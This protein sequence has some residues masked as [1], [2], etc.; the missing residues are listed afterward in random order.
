[1]KTISR[2]AEQAGAK[3][4]ATAC[5]SC[6][7]MRFVIIESY[8]YSGELYPEDDG[9][10]FLHCFSSEGGIDMIRCRECGTKHSPDDFIDIII[11]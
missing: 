3:A 2:S 6:G 7:S 4:P 10:A 5:R 1:M 9:T 11:N 8:A